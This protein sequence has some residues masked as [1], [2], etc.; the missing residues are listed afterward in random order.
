MFGTVVLSIAGRDKGNYFVVTK[1]ED[2]YIY[3]VDGNIH[4]IENPKYKKIKHI[5][6][7]AEC[8]DFLK[9][10]LINNNKVTNQD[11]KRALKRFQKI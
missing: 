8:E 11:I 9:E 10:R 6:I 4:K 2:N 5:E 7:I 1:I 3:I